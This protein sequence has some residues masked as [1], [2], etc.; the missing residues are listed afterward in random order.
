MRG[1]GPR[2]FVRGSQGEKSL[3]RQG[4]EIIFSGRNVSVWRKPRILVT[5]RIQVVL[6]GLKELGSAS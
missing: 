5:N 4:A 6:P 1:C 2:Y 3:L